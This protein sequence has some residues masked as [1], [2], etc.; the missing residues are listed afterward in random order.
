MPTII[1]ES[2]PLEKERKKD[3]IKKI[4]DIFTGYG[5]PKEAVTV[6]IHES[7]LD[8]WGSGGEVHSEK[9]KDKV[10]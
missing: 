9:F 5:I 7:S 4:T 6:I 1:I 10:K 2:W 8:N 3:V